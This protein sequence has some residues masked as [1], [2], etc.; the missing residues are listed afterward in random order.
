M[1]SFL[2]ISYLSLTANTQWFGTIFAGGDF[3]CNRFKNTFKLLIRHNIYNVMPY[4][5]TNHL[6]NVCL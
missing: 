1:S 5:F 2:H 4:F 3:V 6:K